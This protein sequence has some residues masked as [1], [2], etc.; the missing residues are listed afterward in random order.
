MGENRIIMQQGNTERP[1]QSSPSFCGDQHVKCSEDIH[2][3]R[4]VPLVWLAGDYEE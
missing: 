4:L 2:L 1:V 3:E